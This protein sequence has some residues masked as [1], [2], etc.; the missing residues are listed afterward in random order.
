MKASKSILPRLDDYYSPQLAQVPYFPFQ[1]NLDFVGQQNILQTL[2][3][4][5]SRHPVDREVALYGLGGIGYVFCPSVF[6]SIKDVRKSQIAM[7]FAYN[8]L[9]SYPETLIF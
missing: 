5:F 3:D 4:S 7:E 6:L 2:L 9:E 8:L 1:R